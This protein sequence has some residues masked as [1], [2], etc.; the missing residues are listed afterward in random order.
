MVVLVLIPLLTPCRGLVHR[1]KG[2]L[3]YVHLVPFPTRVGSPLLMNFVVHPPP[4]PKNLDF[5][6]P[7]HF[8]YR[9]VLVLFHRTCHIPPL[10]DT[11]QSSSDQGTHN[12]FFKFFICNPPSGVLNKVWGCFDHPFPRLC[13]SESRA[14]D[15][16]A[17]DR[18]SLCMERGV[19]PALVARF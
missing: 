11:D 12:S 1:R 5:P 17:L 9:F 3:L 7:G 10:Q 6:L 16:H 8:L 14:L 4:G 2:L 15:L 13:D 19:S 18:T